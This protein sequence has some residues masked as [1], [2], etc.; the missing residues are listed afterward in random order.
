[1]WKRT[2]KLA[3]TICRSLFSFC[4]L[5]FGVCAS[6]ES[7][8]PQSSTS[9]ELKV[10][11]DQTPS[12]LFLRLLGQA[13]QKDEQ[14]KSVLLTYKSAQLSPL[15]ALMTSFIPQFSASGTLG[16]NRTRQTGL[17]PKS[18]YPTES[19]S[20][21]V[22]QNLF[23]SGAG[24]ATYRSAKAEEKIG[25]YEYQKAL[26]EFLIRCIKAY[27]AVVTAQK[28][29]DVNKASEESVGQQLKAAEVRAEVGEGSATEVALAQAELAKAV[30]RRLQ[31][32]AE[33]YV[34][35]ARFQDLFGELP[36]A[37]L[38]L[39][40]LQHLKTPQGITEMVEQCM[41]KNLD[42]QILLLKG[43]NAERKTTITAAGMLPKVD[44]SASA[45]RSR[46]TPANRKLYGT[47]R[48][49]TYGAEV[50]VT[51]PIINNGQTSNFPAISRAQLE[52][53]AT[54]R[55]IQYQKE[56]TRLK[57]IQVW[58]THNVLK[59]SLAQ[60]EA[61]VNAARLRLEGVT[62]EFKVGSRAMLDVMDAET[63]YLEAQVG[64][65]QN[66]QKYVESIFD[67]LQVCGILSPI[68]FGLNS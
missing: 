64:L 20:L 25:E 44:A 39:P 50:R 3:A 38:K 2:Y 46:M 63:K 67:T 13:Y 11:K 14:I 7:A 59:K 9:T 22:T 16:Y 60:N 30:M 32:E 18:N 5:V 61:Q 57:A 66:E 23:N 17:L 52:A 19:G 21:N 62:E 28:T 43:E 26:Q 41:Q 54:K 65:L 24:I 15:N 29:L 8:T 35:S 58:E 56:Q 37:K 49:T 6:V 31:A 33:L 36:P 12:D 42:L 51:I 4:M 10:E 53:A 27:A 34:A 45:T 40:D 48:Q 47:G 1:M 68:M 55:S